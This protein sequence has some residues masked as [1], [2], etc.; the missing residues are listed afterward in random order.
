VVAF[1]GLSQKNSERLRKD[2][3]IAFL[4]KADLG[5]EKGSENLLTALAEI[6]RNLGKEVPRGARRVGVGS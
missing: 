5:L 2:G 6:V 1:T 4:D 3:A